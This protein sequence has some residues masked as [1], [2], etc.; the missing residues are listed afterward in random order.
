MAA[1]LFRNVLL[2]ENFGRVSRGK[3]NAAMS[4]LVTSLFLND[5]ATHSK[6]RFTEALPIFLEKKAGVYVCMNKTL[7]A[8]SPVWVVLSTGPWKNKDCNESFYSI[9]LPSIR[10]HTWALNKSTVTKRKN[11]SH[12]KKNWDENL[13]WLSGQRVFVGERFDDN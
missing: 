9:L 8:R 11:N 2:E 7:L 6:K 1:G 12:E 3:A 10:H 13:H 5:Y 4:L